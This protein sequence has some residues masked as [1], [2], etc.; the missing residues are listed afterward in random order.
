MRVAYFAIAIAAANV[1][2][3]ERDRV[4]QLLEVEHKRRGLAAPVALVVEEGRRARYV[5]DLAVAIV[6]EGRL[7]EQ[8]GCARSVG[9]L[10]GLNAVVEESG[11]SCKVPVHARVHDI[12]EYL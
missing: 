11:R 1:V 8:V 9:R 4:A 3:R 12:W 2:E 5:L 10:D 6:D 7:V